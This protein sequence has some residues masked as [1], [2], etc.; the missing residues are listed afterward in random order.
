MRAPAQSLKVS[1]NLKLQLLEEWKP[2]KKLRV[3]SLNER[4]V[5]WVED[6]KNCARIYSRM[7]QA[8]AVCPKLLP[9]LSR[10]ASRLL[11]YAEDYGFGNATGTHL[12]GAR[13]SILESNIWLYR[14]LV[15]IENTKSSDKIY[16]TPVKS[17]HWSTLDIGSTFIED[18]K[19]CSIT[20]LSWGITRFGCYW[21]TILEDGR[22]IDSRPTDAFVFQRLEKLICNGLKRHSKAPVRITLS[23]KIRARNKR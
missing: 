15:E 10:W 16:L 7:L 21:R 9:L 12:V 13:P 22:V 3:L 20:H 4:K 2:I 23:K 8:R 17:F 14:L 6:A 19:G 5:S 18:S 11:K 1:S